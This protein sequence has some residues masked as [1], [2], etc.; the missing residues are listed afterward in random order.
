M[1]IIVGSCKP[2]KI[3]FTHSSVLKQFHLD[4]VAYAYKVE[5]FREIRL[6]KNMSK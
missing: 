6:G 4:I 1:E 2:V 3:I 5:L